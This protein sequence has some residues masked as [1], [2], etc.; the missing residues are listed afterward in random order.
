MGVEAEEKVWKKGLSWWLP[1]K[2][3]VL[4]ANLPRMQTLGGGTSEALQLRDRACVRH[5]CIF[6]DTQKQLLPVKELQK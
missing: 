1:A 3:A 2:P 5:M 6:A 4:G